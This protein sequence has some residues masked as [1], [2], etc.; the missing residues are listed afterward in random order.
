LAIWPDDPKGSTAQSKG[1]C[2]ERSGTGQQSQAHTSLAFCLDGFD[3][4]FEAADREFRRAIELKPGHATAH[5]WYSWH[6]ALLG[7][8][9]EAIA[10]MR[11]AQDLDP[12]S[13]II[14]ADLAELLLIAHSP[15]ESIE[16]SRKM[17][18]MDP[19]FG[20]A[21]NQLAQGYLDKHMFAEAIA[22]LQK[23]I[24][25]SGGSPICTANLARA[26]AASG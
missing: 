17:I 23:A 11:K 16:Q 3:W 8:N 22:E 26:Y 1:R 14:G 18:E 2:L 4:N 19:N 15:E 24:Q 12:L 13:L 5:H 25:L 6:L 7:R 10:E 21:H 9:T 20:L